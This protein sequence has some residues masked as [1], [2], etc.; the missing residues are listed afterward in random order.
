MDQRTEKRVKLF[1][2]NRNR[3]KG[4]FHWETAYLHVLCAA[5]Y[6][7]KDKLTDPA[8]LREAVHLI[9]EKTGVFSGF[10]GTS[11]LAIASMA[12][13]SG[14]PEQT[15]ERGLQVYDRLRSNFASSNYLPI[16]AMVIAELAPPHDY[17]RVA[18][19]TRQIYDLMKNNHFFLTS[20]EDSA[21]AALLALSERSDQELARDMEDCYDQLGAKFFSKNSVQVLSHILTISDKP[22]EEKCRRTIELYQR[23]KDNGHKFGT[24]YELP[25]LGVLALSEGEV[26]S[27]ARNIIEIDDFLSGQK[28]FGPFGIEARQRLM[29]AG[30]MA[31]GEY[32]DQETM[33]AAAIN[34][35]ISL[36]VAQQAAMCASMAAATAAAST[37][38]ASN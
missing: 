23:L 15:L 30:I 26:A 11:K 31:Q 18:G 8:S 29:Y 12:D 34:G 24:S 3:I 35:T 9:K 33:Q 1:L 37:A 19:R 7:S 14:R 6:A 27:I 21:S 16:A 28:G 10:K 38:S 25:T 13:L 20:S 2:E 22:A 32:L 4:E 36:I 5:M 17:D